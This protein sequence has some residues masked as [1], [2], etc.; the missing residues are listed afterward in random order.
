MKT[1]KR[2]KSVNKDLSSKY[3]KK[4]KYKVGKVYSIKDYDESDEECSTGLH[5][6][7][8]IYANGYDWNREQEIF[9]S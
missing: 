3:D 9:I 2:F 7:E 5:C 4:F 6:S 1:Y 8:I